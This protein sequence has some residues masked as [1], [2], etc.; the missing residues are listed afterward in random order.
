MKEDKCGVSG[1]MR[2]G[3]VNVTDSSAS[4]PNPL[5]LYNASGKIL[6]GPASSDRTKCNPLTFHTYRIPYNF[7]CG[8]AVGYQYY[9]TTAFG[10]S[11]SSGYNTINDAYLSGLSITYQSNAGRQHIWSYAAGYRESSSSTYNCPCA[12]YAGRAAPAFVGTD[13]YCESGS[14]G[15]PF[16]R[17]Y[18]SNPLWDGKGCYSGS[19]CC[20]NIHAPWF[21]KALP[22]EATSDIEA[23]WC[24]PYSNTNDLTGI[25]LLEVYVY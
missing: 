19:S 9:Y 2:V 6:C 11:T 18:T 25:E 1:V 20:N 5:T 22:E 15:S 8:K 13:F 24:H 10:Y 4:C 17:W 23:R 14:H 21:F 12:R 3:Y 16:N 7:V